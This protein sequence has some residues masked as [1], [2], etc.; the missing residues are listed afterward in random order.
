M[1]NDILLLY[2][3]S[4]EIAC[5]SELKNCTKYFWQMEMPIIMQ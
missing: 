1:N 4:S 2:Y 5:V 3:I